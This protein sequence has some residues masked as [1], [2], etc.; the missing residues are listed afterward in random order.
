MDR[1]QLCSLSAG[2]AGIETDTDRELE[3][4]MDDGLDEY[5]VQLLQLRITM[6]STRSP[7]EIRGEKAN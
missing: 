4:G 7:I 5:T 6:L 2:S 1:F 3:I